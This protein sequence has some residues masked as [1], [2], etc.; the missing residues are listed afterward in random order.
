M[1][2]NGR[3]PAMVRPTIVEADH[4]SQPCCVARTRQYTPHQVEMA[5]CWRRG[6]PRVRCR[7]RGLHRPSGA[8]A[9]ENGQCLLIGSGDRARRAV[10]R[11]PQ[12]G[13]CTTARRA[14]RGARGRMRSSAS[15]RRLSGSPS[16]TWQGGIRSRAR[17]RSDG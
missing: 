6:A 3:G 1:D 4:T 16:P 11:G 10:P 17:E 5:R 2:V 13:F 9:Q 8:H 14:G 12:P 15:V 7:A